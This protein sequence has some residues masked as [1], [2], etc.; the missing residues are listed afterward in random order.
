MVSTCS[1]QTVGV[2]FQL[3][4]NFSRKNSIPANGGGAEKTS[5]DNVGSLN[6]LVGDAAAELNLVDGWCASRDIALLDFFEAR[7]AAY[8]GYRSTLGILAC[9]VTAKIRALYTGK[10]D[11]S[12]T[13][14]YRCVLKTKCVVYV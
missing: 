7:A 3:R 11:P 2:E 8:L 5:A 9:F 1:D 10:A 14:D 4:I 12:A 6:G 13:S